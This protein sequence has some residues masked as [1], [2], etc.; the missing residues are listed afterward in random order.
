MQDALID[1]ES[2]LVDRAS[3]HLPSYGTRRAKNDFVRVI[4]ICTMDHERARF[5]S[6]ASTDSRVTQ[7]GMSFVQVG[8]NGVSSEVA[9]DLNGN[10]GNMSGLTLFGLFAVSAMLIFYS[11][12]NRSR[13]FVLAFAGACAMGSV[14]G[15][16]QRA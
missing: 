14:Y 3:P 8:V 10:P 4:A 16:L 15:F 13:W 7:T 11:L 2:G 5:Y 9:N 1:N 12:E 6:R